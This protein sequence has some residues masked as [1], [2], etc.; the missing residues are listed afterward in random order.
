MDKPV[1]AYFE[2]SGQGRYHPTIHAQ[3]AWNPGEIH[4]GPLGGL[5]VHAIDKH[6]ARRAGRPTRC[7]SAASVSTSWGSSPPRRSRFSRD[8]PAGPHHRARRGAGAHR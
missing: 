7:S 1:P 4:F 6:R 8:H 3:G 2:S 5:I